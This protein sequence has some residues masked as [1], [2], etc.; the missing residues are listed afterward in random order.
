MNIL[1]CAVEFLCLLL[2]VTTLIQLVYDLYSAPYAFLLPASLG[3]E[4]AVFRSV[5]RLERGP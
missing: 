3:L 5:G 2:T 1:P 4:G